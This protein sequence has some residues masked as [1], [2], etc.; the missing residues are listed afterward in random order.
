M[1]TTVTLC[2]RRH[3]AS[4]SGDRAQSSAEPHAAQFHSASAQAAAATEPV[5]ASRSSRRSAIG[6]L[7]PISRGTKN[8]PLDKPTFSSATI[9][10]VG[11]PSESRRKVLSVSIFSNKL[12]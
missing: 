6:S 2:A 1:P 8:T 4:G 11:N 10:E 12:E 7:S 5:V 3:P 9:T